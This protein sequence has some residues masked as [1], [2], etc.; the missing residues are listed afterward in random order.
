M[1]NTTAEIRGI[2]GIEMLGVGAC[3]WVGD[4]GRLPLRA[5]LEANQ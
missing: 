5:A 1:I 2:D 3:Y 4:G